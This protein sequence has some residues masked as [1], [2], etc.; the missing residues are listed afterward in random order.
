MA[1]QSSRRLCAEL[2]QAIISCRLC[3]VAIKT[4]TV[5]C[6]Q[7]CTTTIHV[8]SSLFSPK[9]Q[10]QCHAMPANPALLWR[11]EQ[12]QNR[13]KLPCSSSRSYFRTHHQPASLVLPIL[14]RIHIV[15]TIAAAEGSLG[16]EQGSDASTLFIITKCCHLL[17]PW[18]TLPS[19]Q[20]ASVHVP[21]RHRI[22]IHRTS[23]A[24]KRWLSYMLLWLLPRTSQRRIVDWSVSNRFIAYDLITSPPSHFPQ[25][26]SWWLGGAISVFAI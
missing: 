19:T 21:D 15:R 16:S 17:L 8:S 24:M 14:L 22:P 13:N 6:Q 7:L 26:K 25:M 20:P 1:E 12:Q 10:Q 3:Y 5:F 4:Y 2:F 18:I 23:D 9:E 11:T